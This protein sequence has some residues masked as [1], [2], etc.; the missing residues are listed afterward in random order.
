[1]IYILKKTL[2]NFDIELFL[3]NSLFTVYLI[4]ILGYLGAHNPIV[5]FL[6]FIFWPTKYGINEKNLFAF[7]E[8]G[9]KVAWRG[10]Y[11]SAESIGEFYGLVIL[12]LIFKIFIFKERN[13]KNWLLI[14]PPTLGL[15]LSN[16]RTV[17]VLILVYL[18]LLLTK[19]IQNRKI[20]LVANLI[21]FFAVFFYF[22]LSANL[23]YDFSFYN[24]A[25][26]KSNKFLYS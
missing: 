22:V 10:F 23:Q 13:I 4:I 12:F 26:Y 9:E 19:R 6:I 20:F 3:N 17:F 7:N 8:W 21:I 5:K 25:L 15:Y 2:K 18:G 11:P 24:E 16:N 14:L 1:M